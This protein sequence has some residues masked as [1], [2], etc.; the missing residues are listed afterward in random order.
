MEIGARRSGTAVSHVP[1]SPFHYH[2]WRGERDAPEE[3]ASCSATLFAR[4]LMPVSALEGRILNPPTAAPPRLHNGRSGFSEPDQKPRFLI[5]PVPCRCDHC[6]EG[7]QYAFA[8]AP[9]VPPSSPLGEKKGARGK[10]RE[11]AQ[12]AAWRLKTL[13]TS[14]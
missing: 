12:S 2:E 13:K 7:C 8:P 1:S 6:V 4:R 11:M 10:V 9:H 14:R 5:G 3:V